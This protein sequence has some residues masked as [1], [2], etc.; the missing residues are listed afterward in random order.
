[1]SSASTTK[2][3][4]SKPRSFVKTTL[5]HEAIALLSG[6]ASQ[7]LLYGG[8]RSGKTVIHLYAMV[9]RAVKRKSRHLILRRHFNH[10]KT[11]IW[12]DTLPK[13]LAMAC[14]NL[15][16]TWNH[17]D[18]YV[19]FPNGSQIWI[20][21]LDDKDRTE[22]VLGHEFSTILFNECSQ[23]TYDSVETARTRLA[24]NSGLVLKAYYDENPPRSKHW[25]HRLWIDHSDPMDGGPLADP[26]DYASLLMNPEDNRANLPDGY[27]EQVLGRLSKH[28]RDRFLLG[29]WGTDTEG[30]LWKGD[31]IQRREL[32]ASMDRIVVA[33]DPAVTQTKKSD[34]TG[35]IVAGRL[36][37]W[38]YVLEDLSGRYSPH[39]WGMIVVRAYRRWQADRII[40]EVNN[41]GDLV[42][43]NIRQ[44]DLNVS[45]RAVHA[46][47]GKA[48][49]AEPVAALYEQ[50]RGIHC[51]EFPELEEEMT[52]WVP[53]EGESPNRVDATVWAATELFIE[54]AEEQG[55]VMV[56]D[57][58][59]ISPY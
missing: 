11:S 12:L 42:E 3:S 13:V 20:G 37:N 36:G 9:C 49:R 15:P 21:G 22:K 8:S 41:G 48:V 31:W 53:G 58:R 54:V 59:P 1:L 32:P 57:W 39:E 47:R 40:G 4:T 26:S 10:C 45:Y 35:I 34:E 14:P 51:G 23:L 56:D 2:T 43:S 16:V 44:C 24:E 52:G 29:L 18:Y 33:V 19:E 25:T 7:V 38:F 27:I 6:P 17:T 46:S 55:V 30:A 28:K 50:G 5:Q